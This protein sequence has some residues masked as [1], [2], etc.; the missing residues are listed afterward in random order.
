MRCLSPH[1]R[2]SIN[3]FDAQ[4]QIVTDSRGY[5]HSRPIGLQVMANFENT[6]LLDHEVDLAL[7]SFSFSGLAEGV[8]PLSKIGVFDTEIFCLRWPERE[9]EEIQAQIE[10][11]LRELQQLHPSQFIIAETPT[12]AR[13]WTKYD[14]DSVEGVLAVQQATGTDPA[15]VRRYE[16]EKQ[17]RPEIIEAMKELEGDKAPA[18]EEIVVE[19]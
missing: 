13:P 2:Y 10:E 4:E 18:E 3:V 1:A 14:Q 19:S 8:N 11:R 7:S 12:A 16:Q 6:G 9:R 5:A 17:N 15:V